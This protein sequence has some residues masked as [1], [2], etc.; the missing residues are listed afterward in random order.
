M[1]RSTSP[2]IPIGML[3]LA[4][5]LAGT[6]ACGSNKLQSGHV[7]D[8]ATR[9]NRTPV[10]MPAADEATLLAATLIAQTAYDLLAD[11]ELVAAA[12]REFNRPDGR[13]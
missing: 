13:T 2:S 7:Q 12:W 5:T 8:E 4:A 3:M 10:S 9:A 1:P 11:P 6:L